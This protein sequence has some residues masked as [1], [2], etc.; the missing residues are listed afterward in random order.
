MLF[1]FL[2]FVGGTLKK[3]TKI[4]FYNSPVSGKEIVIERDRNKNFL[5]LTGYNGV[6]KSRVISMVYE[7]LALVR[8]VDSEINKF[9]W[10]AQLEYEGG[11]AIRAIKMSRDGVTGDTLQNYVYRL[12]E[13]NHSLK[14][15][16]CKVENHINQKKS[17]SNIGPGGDAAGQGFGCTTILPYNKKEAKELGASVEMVAY[18][19]DQ[20][21]F[22]YSRD[23]PATIFKGKVNI[24]RTIYTLLYDFLVHQASRVSSK[25][26]MYALFDEYMKKNKKFDPDAAKEFVASKITE[27]QVF[28]ADSDY[29]SSAV[30]VELNKFFA[31]TNRKLVWVDGHPAMNIKDG[32][33]VPWISFSKGEKT[34]LA[35]MLTV[36]LY[37]NSADFVFDE[38]DLSLHLEWQ[39]MLLPAF[40]SLA[41]NAKFIISTHSPA[42]V[43]NTESEQVI[44]MAKF[45]KV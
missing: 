20:V 41:P 43:F 22:N 39:K 11:V 45:H 24:D 36:Y 26:A 44:N 23:V 5:I 29:E 40:L 37:G 12:I 28:G 27:A 18:I 15:F 4:S 10:A 14:D 13:Q 6:G 2:G 38:P 21:Y 35:L 25:D 32:G 7:T 31:H 1:R 34:L 17:F 33:V 3:I 16:Y 19:D 30:F 9:G 42:L 8:N